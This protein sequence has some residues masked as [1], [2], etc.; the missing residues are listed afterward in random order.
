M[1]HI[2]GVNNISEI[3]SVEGVDG[4][5]VGPYDLSASMGLTGQFE[6][7]TFRQAIGQVLEGSR[8]YNVPAGFHAVQP[9]PTEL[10]SRID[11]GYQ[12]FEHG[13]LHGVAV[14]HG[15]RTGPASQTAARRSRREFPITDTDEKLIAAAA[16]TGD[17]R[18][19][20]NG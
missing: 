16:S 1:K 12:F 4:F 6:N 2:D 13:V 17:S 8:K 7:Q 3:M 10:R 20:K 19:P 14:P 11:E 15:A 9:D 18:I 5:I